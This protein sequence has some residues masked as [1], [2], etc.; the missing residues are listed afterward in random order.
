MGPYAAVEGGE[1]IDIPEPSAW[2]LLALG[3]LTLAGR[4]RHR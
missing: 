3:L 1:A 2:V 4:L